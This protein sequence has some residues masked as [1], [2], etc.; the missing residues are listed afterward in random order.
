MELEHLLRYTAERKA[1]DL[2]LKHGMP[3][4]IRLHGS[5]EPLSPQ[6][7]ALSSEDIEKL[8]LS[9]MTPRQQVIFEEDKEIDVSFGISGVGRFRLNVFRQRGTMSMVIRSIPHEVPNIDQL[10]LPPVLKKIAD[11]ERGLILVTGVTGSGKSTTMAAMLSQ[12]NATK[13]KHIITIEDPIEYLIRDNQCIITQRELGSDTLSFSKAL[14]AA[15][16]QDPDVILIGEMRDRKTIET[17]MLAAETGHLVFSTLH[18]ADAKETINRILAVFPPEN[19]QQMRI[20]MANNLKAV[21]SQRL[22]R[23]ADGHGHIPAVEIMINNARIKE[24][25]LHPE[26]HDSILNAIEESYDTLG[27]QSFDQSLMQL[28]KLKRINKNEALKLSSNPQ[29]FELKLQGVANVA[30]E[31]QWQP[32]K[33]DDDEHT[34][35]GVGEG[36][37]DIPALELE[38][39]VDVYGGR[40]KK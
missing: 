6:L 19:H 25:I 21:I 32:F 1:S 18:T 35:P 38:T 12:I 15:L 23:R 16:R 31:N 39:T 10:Q 13:R 28:I 20:Q 11:L 37:D 40:K 30:E 27:M 29:D 36:W 2:H 26:R 4:M 34:A 33:S 9:I 14:R 24:M 5:L 17:A 22:A 7:H 8:A 3:P